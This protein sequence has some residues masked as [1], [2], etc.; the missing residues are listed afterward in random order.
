LEL[1]SKRVN[2]GNSPIVSDGIVI[3]GDRNVV[4]GPGVVENCTSSGIMIENG[5]GNK[6][7]DVSSELNSIGIAVDGSRSMIKGN[8]AARNFV[9]GIRV[10]CCQ[11]GNRITG[12]FVTLNVDDAIEIAGNNNTVSDTRRIPELTALVTGLE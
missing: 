2:C 10:G 8:F 7:I 1:N 12:N 4:K 6:V 9:D 5:T 3:G 11:G